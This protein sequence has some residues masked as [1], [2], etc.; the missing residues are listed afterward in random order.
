MI[1]KLHGERVVDD[2]HLYQQLCRKGDDLLGTKINLAD[3]EWII[4]GG[5]K[6]AGELDLWC[7]S[8]VAPAQ[9]EIP[10]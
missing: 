2:R 7:A 5:N 9:V 8:Q 1:Y 3:H 6:Q 10:E 4:A